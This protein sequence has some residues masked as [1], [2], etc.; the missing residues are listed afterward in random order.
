[1]RDIEEHGMIASAM[2]W[3]GTVGTISAYVLLS[4]GRW[5]PASLRYSAI[6]GVGGVLC[7]G[8]SAAYGAWPSVTSNLLWSVIAV[9]SVTTTLRE[10]R[11]ERVAEVHQLP[12]RPS[13]P[14]PPTGPQPVLV[15]A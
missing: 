13:D 10:R 5:S 12:V 2:G 14:E 9:H 4:R 15:A 7:A 6:N 8:A 3:I 1:M 11:A